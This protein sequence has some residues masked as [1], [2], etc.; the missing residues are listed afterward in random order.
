M[1]KQVILF[2][3]T[4]GILFSMGMG[5]QFTIHTPSVIFEDGGRIGGGKGNDA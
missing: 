4:P 1:N 5:I 3:L 2:S